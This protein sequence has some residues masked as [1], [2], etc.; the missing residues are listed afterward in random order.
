VRLPG[1]RPGKVPR[2]VFEQTYGTHSIEEEAM[3]DVVPRAYA[4]AV[5]EHDLEPVARPNIELLPEEDGK[6]M[7]VK[8]VVEVRPEIA[9]KTYKGLAITQPV[10][11]V[12]D[13][14]VEMSLQQLAKER[15]TLVPVER[16]AKLGDVVTMDYAGSIDGVPFDGGTAQGQVTE[17]DERRF[18]PGFAAGIVGMSA[19]DKKDIEAQ[20]PDDYQQTDLA[21][22]KAVF[23]IAVHDVKE[24]EL[25]ALDDE[26]AK[27]ISET[28]SMDE[29]RADVRTRLDAIAKGRLRRDTGNQAMTQ[30][31]AAH[32]VAL[33]ESMVEGELEQ[34]LGDT[35]QEAQRNGLSLEEYLK[36]TDKS[37]EDLRKELRVD[38]EQR[39]KGTL[40]IEAI[41]KAEKI[42]A[43]PAD[44]Q[45]ELAS[46][47]AQYRQPVEMIRK[48]LG[49]NVHS[50]VDGIVRNKTL[51]LIIDNAKITPAPAVVQAT[52]PASS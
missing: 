49:N 4:A 24:L 35:T 52:G 2:K 7:R 36:A 40:L 13:A 28:M 9:L 45:G 43:T 31:L 25:P 21:G 37:E 39:V 50:L 14:D 5:R 42:E 38:A 41:A 48:A 16:P 20:F 29:L 51:D 6:P 22:K 26:F 18:I 10:I 46:L 1:F 12:T 32:E 19:G 33:P 8:A 11:D 47:A 3:E 17:L 27:H 15:A 34:M 30:L 44:L 23:V